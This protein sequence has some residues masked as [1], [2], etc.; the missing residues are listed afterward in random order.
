PDLVFATLPRVF[1]A[2]PGG[3]LLGGFFFAGLT[4]AAFLSAVA[5]FEVLVA[6][7]T[8]N[9]RLGRRP[10]VW[11]VAGTV[12][13]FSLPPTVNMSW[14]V[15]WDLAF[16]SGLQMGGALLAALCVGWALDRGAA[17]R[18][19][20]SEPEGPESD[21]ATGGGP[22]PASVRWLYL[23][24]RYV[25]PAAIGLVAAWWLASDVLGVA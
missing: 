13:L 17:L 9:T 7:L 8:D 19:L 5:A 2:V 22:E 16:G 20:A 3:S 14:F 18:Q 6:G 4:A 1:G 15:P 21:G 24:V 10:A 25:I 23:W 11:T 12:A